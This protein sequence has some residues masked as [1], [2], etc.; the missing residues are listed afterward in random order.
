MAFDFK[1][2]T[3]LPSTKGWGPGFPNCQPEAR[4]GRS[5][6]F[7]PGVHKDIAELVKLLCEE[8]ERR[9]YK[10]L[11][12]QSGCWGYGCRGTKS[13]NSSTPGNTPSFHS[14]GLGFDINAPQNPFGAPK[15][16]NMPAWVVALWREYG[17]FWLGPPIKD[18]MHFSFCGSKAD[19]KAMTIK[20][21]KKLGE[22][23]M[24]DAE[25]A[26]LD[27]AAE[28][29]KVANQMFAAVKDFLEETPPPEHATVERK[30]T[31]KALREA[32]AK[33]LP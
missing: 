31:Y 25:K 3:P 17:F 10:F 15:P 32:A 7:F 28:G 8:M 18:W 16:N 24:T 2:P 27:N 33:P 19:A 6:V 21:R 23:D 26:K 1:Y 14:W 11:K 22:D 29:A 9:G 4:A 30:R 12:L 13:A 5:D 20:A